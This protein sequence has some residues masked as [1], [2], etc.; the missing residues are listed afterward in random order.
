VDAG[1][2]TRKGPQIAA[3]KCMSSGILTTMAKHTIFLC[4]EAQKCNGLNSFAKTHLISKNSVDALKL[5]N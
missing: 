2:I 4:D 1:E 5:L 3:K